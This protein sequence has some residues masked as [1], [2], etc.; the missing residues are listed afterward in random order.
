M[1][2]LDAAGTLRAGARLQ[3][4][5]TSWYSRSNMQRR[6][7]KFILFLAL[8]LTGQSLLPA[9]ALAQ[10]SMRCAGAPASSA[11]CAQDTVLSADPAVVSKHFA[12]LACCRAM[13]H[14]ASMALSVHRSATPMSRASLTAPRCLLS[15]SILST[16]PAM[17][18]RQTHRWLLLAAPALAPPV[19][20]SVSLS[21]VSLPKIQLAPV[22]FALPPSVL[23]HLHGLRAPPA[24]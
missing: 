10:V 9:A 23:T 7:H 17:L 22:S 13:S 16:K 20:R 5:N 4:T 12:G 3:F 6:P 1:A 24:A 8:L 18:G 21:P 15:V 14:C 2:S 19:V 11:A